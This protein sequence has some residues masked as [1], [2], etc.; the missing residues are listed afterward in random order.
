MFAAN[1]YL[2]PRRCS[3]INHILTKKVFVALIMSMVFSL[4]GC[5]EQID[6][7]DIRPN[8]PPPDPASPLIGTSWVS[9]TETLYFES[10]ETV[11][12][13]GH[14]RLHY[15]YDKDERNG[16]VDDI[17]W[18]SVMGDYEGMHFHAWRNYP[19]GRQ[20]YF[21]RTAF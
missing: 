11:M 21:T 18:F 3:I 6:P 17:R 16:E 20:E 2:R 12:W 15:W 10:A 19:C 5:Q 13:N 4:Y 1:A 14:T 8:R 7:R 9:P